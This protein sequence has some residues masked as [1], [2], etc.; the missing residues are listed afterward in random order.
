MNTNNDIVQEV[1]TA[2]NSCLA[3]NAWRIVVEPNG[4]SFYTRGGVVAVDPDHVS[5]YAT[6]TRVIELAVSI[7]RNEAFEDG[8][9]A[10]ET[11]ASDA[12]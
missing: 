1:V 7:I 9:S 6:L 12:D 2:L 10:G 5:E 3:K 4:Y 8:Y 11:T